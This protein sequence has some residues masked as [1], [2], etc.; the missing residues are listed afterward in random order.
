MDQQVTRFRGVETE[1]SGEA[2]S[3]LEPVRGTTMAFDLACDTC[4]FSR[5]IDAENSA[6]TTARDH[7]SDH[8]SHFVFIYDEE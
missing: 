3:V 6:Y 7:E 5:T 8:P 4:E 2:F 1:R